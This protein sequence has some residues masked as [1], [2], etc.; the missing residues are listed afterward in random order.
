MGDGQ[1]GETVGGSVGAGVS[2]REVGCV[3][4][5][6]T[7]SSGAYRETDLGVGEA[8]EKFVGGSGGCG[9]PGWGGQRWQ[10]TNYVA[11]LPRLDILGVSMSRYDAPWDVGVGVVCC[12]TFSCIRHLLSAML[13]HLLR[14]RRRNTGCHQCKP[15]RKACVHW[16][17]QTWRLTLLFRTLQ[18][19]P[20]WGRRWPDVHS[21]VHLLHRSLRR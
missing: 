7:P 9:R 14:L 6:S 17:L 8:M 10:E 12:S 2:A 20:E 5:G 1:R 16:M 19:W 4:G 18:T 21:R 15:W 11:K 13:H 3:K